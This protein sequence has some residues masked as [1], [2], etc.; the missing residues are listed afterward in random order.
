ML[1]WTV[2]IP[3]AGSLIFPDLRFHPCSLIPCHN[4]SASFLHLK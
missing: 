1:L 2:P 4:S 3:T